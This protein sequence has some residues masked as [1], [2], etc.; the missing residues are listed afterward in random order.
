MPFWK[1]S[2][3]WIGNEANRSD[4]SMGIDKIEFAP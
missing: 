3:H 2:P 1:E 4:L